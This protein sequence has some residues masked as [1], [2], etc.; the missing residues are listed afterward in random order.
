MLDQFKQ[1]YDDILFL[2]TN[3][4]QILMSI[5]MVLMSLLMPILICLGTVAT[6]IFLKFISG[7]FHHFQNIDFRETLTYEKQSFF[8][9]LGLQSDFP[10]DIVPD[11]G[12]GHLRYYVPEECVGELG[13]LKQKLTEQNKSIWAI[14]FR[15]FVQ[16]I[17]LIWAFYIKIKIDNLWLP[18]DRR[19]GK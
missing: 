12:L 6:L 9:G 3:Y 8:T 11:G 14:W 13:A 2:I 4:H 7:F 18:K 17:A 19:I 16:I 15:L 1:Y 5:S 10:Q